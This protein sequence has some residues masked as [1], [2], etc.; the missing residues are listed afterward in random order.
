MSNEKSMSI[1][2]MIASGMSLPEIQKEL[3][4][5]V[6]ARDE[7]KLA[8]ARKS[9]KINEARNKA[10]DAMLKY[11]TTLGI[12]YSEEERTM[13]EDMFRQIEKEMSK[14]SSIFESFG[15]KTDAKD[16]EVKFNEPDD[17]DWLVNMVK[18]L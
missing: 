2:E 15:T 9:A 4:R 16:V 18:N 10:V 7:A 12:P 14:Y 5:K 8:E 17:W 11:L 3:T 13:T 6:A 1:D